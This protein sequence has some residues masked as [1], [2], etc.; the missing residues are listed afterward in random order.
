MFQSGRFGL[1]LLT[2]VLLTTIGA[3]IPVGYH[4]GVINSP[5]NVSIS[6]RTLIQLTNRVRSVVRVSALYEKL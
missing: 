3:T 2:V 1:P 5:A 4:I 6:T